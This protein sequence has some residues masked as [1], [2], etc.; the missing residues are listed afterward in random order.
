MLYQLVIAVVLYAI[1][2]GG[3]AIGGIEF[4]TK[5]FGPIWFFGTLLF[6]LNI[7][8]MSQLLS[9]FTDSGRASSII[10]IFV[11]LLEAVLGVVWTSS[12]YG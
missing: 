5:T 1:I 8:V 2:I 4:I 11:I 10:S 3:A 9:S 7:P 6:I 12:F